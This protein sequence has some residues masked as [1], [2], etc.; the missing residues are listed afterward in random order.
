MF[1]SIEISLP[2]NV[3]HTMDPKFLFVLF[4]VEVGSLIFNS[5][6]MASSEVHVYNAY[7][8][9]PVIYQISS[10]AYTCFSTVNYCIYENKQLQFLKI[11]DLVF[12]SIIVVC[13]GCLFVIIIR[14]W[15]DIKIHSKFKITWSSG[16]QLLV[17][18]TLALHTLLMIILFERDNVNTDQCNKQNRLV[19]VENIYN[20][21][22]LSIIEVA[23][24][25]FN[26]V[27]RQA[28]PIN[29]QNQEFQYGDQADEHI[30]LP[31]SENINRVS[32]NWN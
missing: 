15:V 25:G 9:L 27:N 23:Y 8:E 32:R 20:Y 11:L 31:S 29:T 10:K 19:R 2:G 3:R 4:F 14:K 6:H 7:N 5:L 24:I 30:R 21:F 1:K 22:V 26:L 18:F 28:A 16:I 13:Y 12:I 17:L